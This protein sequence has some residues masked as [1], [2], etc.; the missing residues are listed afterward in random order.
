M[1][2]QEDLVATSDSMCAKAHELWYNTL[3]NPAAARLKSAK[4]I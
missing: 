1:L 4:Q 2:T 3:K